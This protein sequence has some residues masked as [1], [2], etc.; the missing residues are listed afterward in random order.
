[1]M[2]KE[3]AWQKGSGA[4]SSSTGNKGVKAWLS[5]KNPN[6]ERDQKKRKEGE[7]GRFNGIFNSYARV[8]IGK[9]G[10]KTIT[11]TGGGILC[12]GNAFGG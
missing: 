4:K 8:Q 6:R 1:V 2:G 3:A 12:K 7:G 9:N 11:H 5:Y 10:K